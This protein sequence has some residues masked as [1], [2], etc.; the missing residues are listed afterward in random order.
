MQNSDKPVR[1][2]MAVYAIVMIAV[3]FIAKGTG[4]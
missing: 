3:A 1:L 2:G 4:V